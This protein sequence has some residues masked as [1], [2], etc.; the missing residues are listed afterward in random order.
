MNKKVTGIF[1]AIA[2][3]I[4]GLALVISFIPN[5]AKATTISNTAF[6]TA[7]KIVCQSETDLPNWGAGIP[8][9]ITGTTATDYVATHPNCSIVPDW[10][11]EWAPAWATDGGSTTLGHV[12][13]YTLFGT[14]NT[15]EVS[16]EGTG[17]RIWVRELLQEGYLPFSGL[18]T[19][20]NVSAEL[21]C[22]EDGLNYDN[23]D[24]VLNPQPG[25]TYHCVAWN[26]L[27]ETTQVVNTCP[28]PD[29]LGDTSAQTIGSS[30]GSEP[31]VQMILNASGYASVNATND[32]KEYQVWNVTGGQ[33]VVVSPEFLDK[34]SAN[35][36][37]FGYYTNGDINTFNP[38]FKNGF[39]PGFESTPEGT[40]GA[41]YTIPTFSASTLGFAIKAYDGSNIVTRT[42]QNALNV[43]GNDQVAVY[44]P[45]SNE[46]ILAFED[47][48]NGDNDYNDIVV[49]VELSCGE[50]QPQN[51]QY[52]SIYSNTDTKV[53][54][55]KIGENDPLS[56]NVPS[57]VVSPTA[58]TTQ[59]WTADVDGTN[60]DAQWV[61]SEDPVSD[62]TVDKLV[63]FTRNFTVTDVGTSAALTVASDNVYSV[64]L[65]N[66]LIGFSNSPSYNSVAGDTFNIP[67]LTVGEHTLKFIVH[68]QAQ[69]G[70]ALNNPGGLIF[71]LAL[72]NASCTDGGGN[73]G[74]NNH[75]P[76]ITLLGDTSIT[77]TIGQTYVE[78]GAKASD[79]EDFI[80]FRTY[81]TDTTG[82]T[83]TGLPPAG[84]LT[85][86]TTYTVTYKFTDSEGADSN[87]VTRMVYVV[88][89]TTQCS[90]A[91]DN[92]E[93]DFIDAT[94]PGCHTDG[95]NGNSGSYD[96]NDNDENTS[97]GEPT[98]VCPDL[99]G[100]QTS[101]EDCDE[102][103]GGG[104]GTGDVCPDIEGVQ[105]SLEEC[106][107]IG[108]G[109]G[110]I[111]EATG[112]RSGGRSGSRGG[113]FSGNGIV[114][115]ASTGCG[116][117]LNDYIQFGAQN[118]PEEV[119]KLQSFL[120]E[121]LGVG[122]K[123]NGVYDTQTLAAVNAFQLKYKE[124]ILTPWVKIGLHPNSDTPTG[125]VYRTTQRK[126]NDIYCKELNLPIPDLTNELDR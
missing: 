12:D 24:Y 100:T 105:T 112:G 102:D 80:G 121:L 111:T 71:R 69:E 64:Y 43:G 5:T 70:D 82:F 14:S 26:T 10:Q 93:D 62:W 97:N 45:T 67:S 101:P 50:Q 54:E 86:S 85:A 18:T 106:D 123:I 47:L 92:D 126:I 13:G 11:F 51:P 34:Y 120:N 98:D 42:S 2:T 122:L 68:N 41:S 17:D 63:T 116:I 77:L 103:N 72:T 109:D 52:C 90:D 78:S 118:D 115:G 114:L 107:G 15:A 32:Q 104:G 20:Q 46:Y 25:Q 79:T 28:L 81:P 99:A 23:Y 87:T 4:S 60:T 124:E 3:T 30:Y 21:Y 96:P 44:N 59:F 9:N 48:I 38:I 37:V 1:T 113:G 8:A 36:M 73:G 56:M 119:N 27:A 57:V 65:D 33:N 40:V 55:V 61:W 125:Y 6:I 94:D 58:V 19:T 108:G 53:V 88:P 39:V 49:S 66:T 31:S 89:G 83:V 95:N 117:Y 110:I 16:L 91:I 74:S 22:Y 29:T 84:T 35:T 76:V 75:A 7:T